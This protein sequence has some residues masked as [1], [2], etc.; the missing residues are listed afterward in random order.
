MDVNNELSSAVLRGIRIKSIRKTLKM[1][2]K[3]LGLKYDIPPGTIQNWEDGRFGGLTEKGAKK[4]MYAFLQEG[5]ACNLEWLMYGTSQN[6][7]K[8]QNALSQQIEVETFP[9]DSVAIVR[10]LECFYQFNRNA[11]DAIVADDSMTPYFY[12]GDHVAGR[13]Y[14]GKEIQRLMGQ[15]CIVQ[16][17]LGQV[18]VRKLQKGKIDNSYRLICCNPETMMQSLDNVKLFSAAPVIW[19]RRKNSLEDNE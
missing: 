3:A 11:V 2:R 5:I 17:E 9:L 13:R 10:E 19:I 18:L 14:F 16:T 6:P 12:P 1:S 7:L 8:Q 4:M 15:N